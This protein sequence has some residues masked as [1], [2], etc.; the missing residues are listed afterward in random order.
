MPMTSPATPGGKTPWIQPGRQRRSMVSKR[1]PSRAWRPVSGQRSSLTWPSRTGSSSVFLV[2]LR[3][4][5]ARRPR[6]VSFLPRSP[7]RLSQRQRHQQPSRHQPPGRVPSLPTY[8]STMEGG[9]RSTQLEAR[10]C[11]RSMA[12]D[13]CRRGG[14]GGGGSGGRRP[15]LGIPPASWSRMI[16]S[17]T[18]RLSQTPALTWQLAGCW[19]W[20]WRQFRRLLTDGSVAATAV[21]QTRVCVAPAP[22]C[23]TQP[24]NQPNHWLLRRQPW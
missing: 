21:W 11:R 5:S 14:G 16:P 12:G 22:F 3:A 24:A 17:V 4:V 7:H 15:V 9:P 19:W 1:V 2:I 8:T 18:P 23:G 13:S 10:C 6:L 20:E